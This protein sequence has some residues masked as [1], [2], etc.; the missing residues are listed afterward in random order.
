MIENMP[1]EALKEKR[2]KYLYESAKLLM[3]DLPPFVHGDMQYLYTQ[4]NT[5]YLDM[6]S[7]FSVNSMG[8][9]NQ[10]VN[11]YIKKQLDKYAHSTQ[12]FLNEPILALSDLLYAR[13]P[14]NLEKFMYLNSGAEAND[15]AIM[16]AKNFTGKPGVLHLQYS[17]HGRTQ[18]TL[19]VTGMKMW[20]PYNLSHDH[21]FEVPTYY[22]NEV[23]S[24]QAIEKIL[25]ENKEISCMIFEMIQVNGGVLTTESAY[26]KALLA[27]LH[28]HEVLLIIDE[29][30]TC[31]GRT[32]A[33]CAFQQY[34]IEPDILVM[35]KGVGNGIGLSTCITRKE[36]ADAYKTPSVSTHGGNLIAC[37]SGIGVMNYFKNHDIQNHIIKMSGILDCV[38]EPL[39]K[40]PWV[41]EI[42]GIGL[43]RGIEVELEKFPEI[44]K[45]I[46]DE[47]IIV[48]VCGLERNVILIEPPLIINEKDIT[49]FSQ[50]L[51]RVLGV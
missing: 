28:K 45:G 33:F 9:A 15:F 46:F 1:I 23:A 29:A 13:L 27:L 14:E 16:L 25:T 48:G 18:H 2:K 6:L 35:S 26:F 10:E 12:V 31:M 34:G 4:E 17:L 24:L 30:Q 36:I 38:L 39:K 37:A 22:K 47:K 44:I 19:E 50:V 40:S 3:S 42:R 43:I 5:P 49:V 11:H 7:G 20:H 8:H 51:K 21:V 41:K 32:G